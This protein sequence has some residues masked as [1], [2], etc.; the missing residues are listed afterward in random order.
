MR[1]G[2]ASREELAH[3]GGQQAHQATGGAGSP[4]AH[5]LTACC[6]CRSR[7]TK[8]DPGLPRCGPCERSNSTCEY[9]DTT[10]G[11]TISRLYVIHL[12]KKVQALEEELD[13][14]SQEQYESPD[15][16]VLVRS[17]GYVRVKENDES[18]YLGPSSGI[19]VSETFLNLLVINVRSDK[20]SP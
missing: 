14:L 6:R 12:Q 2:N 18:R 3:S 17:G 20:R 4:K 5:T 11:K 1:T 15:A 7:K 9:L 19:A 13:Q 8:C 10:K 16:E